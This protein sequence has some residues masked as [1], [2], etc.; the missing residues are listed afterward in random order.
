MNGE[1]LDPTHA[2][3]RVPQGSV[4]GPLLFLVYIDGVMDVPLSEVSQLVPYADDILL[5]R[6]IICQSDYS[7]INTINSWVEEITTYNLM[8]PNANTC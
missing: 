3:S 8:Y 1:S 7:A 4:L 2:L 6:P 5:Y